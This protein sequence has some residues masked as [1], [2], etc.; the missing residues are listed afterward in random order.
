ML[1]VGLSRAHSP[2]FLFYARFHHNNADIHNT[3][4]T[5]TF[6]TATIAASDLEKPA[7]SSSTS[8]SSSSS[9]SIV[10]DVIQIYVRMYT[11]LSRKYKVQGSICIQRCFTFASMIWM[12]LKG[13]ESNYKYRVRVIVHY[14]SQH[15]W[16][17]PRKFTD[18][19]IEFYVTRQSIR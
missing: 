6:P 7:S 5:Y 3:T 1:F 4:V 8:L 13:H 18:R 10:L 19:H 9:S 14:V 16:N 11:Y 12:S 15:R 17:R 2:Y